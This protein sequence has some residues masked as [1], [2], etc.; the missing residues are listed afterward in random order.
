MNLAG[1][2][3]FAPPVAIGRRTFG[4]PDGPGV[5]LWVLSTW[6]L[7]FGFAYAYQ[8]WTGHANRSV[9]T[10]GVWGK[11]T[12]GVALLWSATTGSISPVAGAAGLPDLLCAA[13]FSVW[14]WTAGRKR[15]W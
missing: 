6:I 3:A 2:V 11:T 5:Y 1:A 13:V 10:L 9:L 7:A 15:R 14:L 4:L 8:G 12:F